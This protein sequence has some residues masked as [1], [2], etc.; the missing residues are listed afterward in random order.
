MQTLP[1]RRDWCCLGW[2]SDRQFSSFLR[3]PHSSRF[4][5]PP[6]DLQMDNDD[7]DDDGD[8]DGDGDG[9]SDGNGDDDGD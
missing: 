2:W 7:E 6:L 9:D 8:G 3:I 1:P 5:P 4:W